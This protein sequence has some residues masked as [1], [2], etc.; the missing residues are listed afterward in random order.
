[1]WYVYKH[2]SYTFHM[3]FCVCVDLYAM[4]HTGST[5]YVHGKLGK[6]V[7]CR[8]PAC[9]VNTIR[10]RYPNPAPPQPSQEA[11]TWNLA[12]KHAS[13]RQEHWG[14]HLQPLPPHTWACQHTHSSF[15]RI[16]FYL[17]TVFFMLWELDFIPSYRGLFGCA[18][19]T[20][21]IDVVKSCEMC[22][23]NHPQNWETNAFENVVWHD[24][25]IY[26]HGKKNVEKTHLLR[27]YTAVWENGNFTVQDDS[28]SQLHCSF[29]SLCCP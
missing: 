2:S 16:I 5:H 25:V 6:H 28:C 11:S 12:G 27:Q 3:T 17:A 4:R 14:C 9:V 20:V 1:M 15:C 21:D 29:H 13:P 23:S 22:V 7:R 24:T 10:Q 8:L 26:L 18:V 19:A